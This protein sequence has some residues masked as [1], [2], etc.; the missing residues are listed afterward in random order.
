MAHPSDSVNQAQGPWMLPCL[1]P[2]PHPGLVTCISSHLISCPTS[3]VHFWASSLQTTVQ[4]DESFQNLIYPGSSDVQKS[5][6]VP[7]WKKSQCPLYHFSSV[8][9]TG[10]SRHVL[11]LVHRKSH[12]FPL[13]T[14]HTMSQQNPALG[15]S[16]TSFH[17]P[18]GFR[19][20]HYPAFTPA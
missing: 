10:R 18:V 15:I 1:C 17:N 6:V 13:T 11:P 3:L 20:T 19:T 2:G 4:P 8:A 5:S 9:A 12:C 7:H 16:D 14:P